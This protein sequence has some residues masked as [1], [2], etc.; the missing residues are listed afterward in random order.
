MCQ[1]RCRSSHRCCSLH[2]HIST[3]DP[4]LGP[5][6]AARP[7]HSHGAYLR[8]VLSPASFLQCFD[9]S[10]LASF[11]R[12]TGRSVSEALLLPVARQ[13]TEE[14]EE[15]KRHCLQRALRSSEPISTSFVALHSPA[16]VLR[17]P[18]F[19][20]SPEPGKLLEARTDSHRHLMTLPS[21]RRLCIL[22][23]LQLPSFDI[24]RSLLLAF[25]TDEEDSFGS[26]LS[27]GKLAS[28][29]VG[30]TEAGFCE[31]LCCFRVSAAALSAFAPMVPV[32]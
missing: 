24:C 32:R 30:P 15:K 10:F 29:H 26:S 7:R 25:S 8:K 17:P 23:G 2:R 11:S 3:G 28:A 1:H 12:A 9:R 22:I 21:D 19:C 16:A 18:G 13:H 27:R 31:P 4:C 14:H 20:P 6:D 5:A